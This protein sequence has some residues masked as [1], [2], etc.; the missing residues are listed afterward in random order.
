MR[1]QVRDRENVCMSWRWREEKGKGEAGSPLSREPDLGL[2]P[3][4]LGSWPEPKA[5]A[6]LIE[7]P[8]VPLLF[9]FEASS[10]LQEDHKVDS[11]PTHSVYHD[12]LVLTLNLVELPCI[13][14]S[15]KLCSHWIF[16]M[17]LL[18]TVQQDMGKH[19]YYTY[20]FCLGAHF[21]VPSNFTH[22][23]Q[24]QKWNC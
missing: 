13:M 10:D 12:Y 19:I 22:K 3:R 24:L 4:T 18:Q 1:E 9:A 23:T 5:D 14:G 11:D 20:L 2:D 7:L 16:Q 15:M 17:G 8:R 6:Q 21:L